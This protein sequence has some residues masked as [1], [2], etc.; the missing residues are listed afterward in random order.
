MFCF[1]SVYLYY[2][3]KLKKFLQFC[4]LEVFGVYN[5]AKMNAVPL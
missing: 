2:Q 5:T 4:S 1:D 3:K